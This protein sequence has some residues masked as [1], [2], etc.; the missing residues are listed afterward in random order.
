MIDFGVVL[1]VLTICMIAF[2]SPGP[3]FMTVF[4]LS[5]ARG[6]AEGVKAAAGIA[7]GIAFYTWI[8]VLGLSAVLTPDLWI[9]GAI[10]ICGGLYL[11]YLGV[12]MWR[13]ALNETPTL[14]SA[15]VKTE[16]KS[17]Y[18]TALLTS[19]TNPKAIAFFASIFALGFQ[20]D[21]SVPTK[22]VIAIAVPLAGFAWFVCIAFGA[23]HPKMRGIYQRLRRGIDRVA[24]TILAVFGVRLLFSTR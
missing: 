16:W 2:I 1:K 18:K 7:T 9:M 10:K 11:I 3:D 21:T 12:V 23:S 20:P 8:S 5:L 13:S 14:D 4:S 17:A 24:G 19:L 22:T 15:C 6:S